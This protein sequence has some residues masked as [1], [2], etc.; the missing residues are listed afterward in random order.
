[1]HVASITTLTSELYNLIATQKE[2]L[3]NAIE[4]LLEHYGLM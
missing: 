1:M 3:G 4:K 2:K